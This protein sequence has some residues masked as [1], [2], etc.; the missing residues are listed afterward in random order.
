MQLRHV[1]TVNPASEAP[2]KVTAIAWC[3]SSS[4]LALATADRVISLFDENGEQRRDKFPTKPVSVGG[5][6]S[7]S[8]RCAHWSEP[9]SLTLPIPFSPSVPLLLLLLLLRAT[10]PG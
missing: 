10:H 1:R 4:R 8:Q 3:P 9:I 5:R 7:A 6:R 2:L